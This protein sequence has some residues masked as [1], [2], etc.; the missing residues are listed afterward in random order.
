MLAMPPAAAIELFLILLLP[1]AA[2]RL[3][4]AP[5]AVLLILLALLGATTVLLAAAFLPRF[6]RGLS[7]RFWFIATLPLHGSRRRLVP[8]ITTS[9]GPAT[10]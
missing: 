5:P 8:A 2:T 7:S 3:T 10:G 6:C 9:R 1:V 4:A